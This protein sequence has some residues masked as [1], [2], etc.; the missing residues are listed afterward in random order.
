M[1]PV[2]GFREAAKKIFLVVQ[3]IRPLPPY[4]YL[5]QRAFDRIFYWYNFSSCYAFWGKTIAKEYIHNCKL[6][7]TNNH[8]NTPPPSHLNPT[9]FYVFLYCVLQGIIRHTDNPCLPPRPETLEP[10]FDLHDSL[11]KFL[12]G[13][14]KIQLE[15]RIFR[16][17]EKERTSGSLKVSNWDMLEH[18]AR[19]F[20]IRFFFISK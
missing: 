8:T 1:K 9:L 16:I 12:G 4:S 11:L 17:S 10:A 18:G 14:N 3:P 19:S 15:F 20:E 13:C 5:F 2:F 6:V 7:L